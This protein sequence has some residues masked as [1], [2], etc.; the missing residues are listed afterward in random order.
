MT[1]TAWKALEKQLG[2][3]PP[4]GFSRLSAEQLQDLADAIL[5]AR[6]RQ[7]AELAAAGDQALGHIPK[8]LRGPLRR[9]LG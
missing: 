8:L 3:P 4:D 9:V 2:G 7:S 1:N 6:H 5:D